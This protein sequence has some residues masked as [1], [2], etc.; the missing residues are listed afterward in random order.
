MLAIVESVST[1]KRKGLQRVCNSYPN[2]RC[3]STSARTRT[4]QTARMIGC[5]PPA[6]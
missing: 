3:S 2:R 4:H 1:R 5:L 6:A